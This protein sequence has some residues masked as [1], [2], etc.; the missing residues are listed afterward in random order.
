MALPMPWQAVRGVGGPIRGHT[1][2]AARACNRRSRG[3]S[4][5]R[6]EGES[7]RLPPVPLNPPRG[8]AS[9]PS[10]S[11]SHPLGS[12][13]PHAR[14][15]LRVPPAQ[16][17]AR[18]FCTRS[19]RPFP[20]RRPRCMCAA[21]V[22]TF[23]TRTAGRSSTDSPACGRCRWAMARF[24]AAPP[25]CSPTASVPQSGD[26]PTRVL[27][28]TDAHRRGR[29]PANGEA[30]LFPHLLEPGARRRLRA[31]RKAP[32]L[33]SVETGENCL[34]QRRVRRK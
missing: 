16:A 3:F 15:R 20:A 27:C 26:S 14:A 10:A 5:V 32:A 8:R 34:H 21:R 19:T 30:A 28:G 4:S 23:T 18:P 31:G 25:R 12:G 17:R 24:P 33:Y 6:N 29:R 11:H 22:C 2:A 1:A 7:G 9:R 13:R